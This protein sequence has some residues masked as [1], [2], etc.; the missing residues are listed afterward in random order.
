MNQLTSQEEA[1]AACV[2]PELDEPYASALK[3]AVAHICSRF[4][5][6]GIV[7][8][9]SILRG[10][11]APTSDLDIYVI[12][13]GTF[14]QRVQKYFCG[15][16][17]EIFVNP[18]AT[19]ETYLCDEAADGRPIT[20]H[21]LATGF[22]VLDADPVVTELRGKSAQI[23]ASPPVFPKD[24]VVWARYMA[25]CRYEDASDMISRDAA[26]ADMLMGP[27]L[28]DMLHFHLKKN[29]SFVP[30]HKDLLSVVEQQDPAIGGLA[31][32]YWETSSHSER[33]SLAAQL[34]DLILGVRG[35]FEWE[36]KPQEMK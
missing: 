35:F 11:A 5:P 10:D 34:A 16:P 15:V 14:R 31:R 28:C 32:R 27:V 1:F 3:E 19:I 36:T 17:A 4:M 26:A 22:V 24:A 29:G 12:H 21:M 18:P 25:A 33:M 2:W 7:A 6:A 8:A 13:R 9:G 20:A 30:R 23:L